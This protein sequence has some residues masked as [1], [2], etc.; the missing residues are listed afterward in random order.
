MSV[1][2]VAR[3]SQRAFYSNT[4][5]HLEIVAPGGNPRDGS[6]TGFV[7]QATVDVREFDPSS[8]IRPRFDQYFEGGAAGTSMAAPHV[9]GLAALLYTQGINRPAAIEAA[10]K[11]FATDLGTAGRDNDYGHGLINA[12]DSL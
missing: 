4:G 2:D 7:W 5:S 10:I 8:V 1:G 6:P 11:R 9:A 12:R 3:N